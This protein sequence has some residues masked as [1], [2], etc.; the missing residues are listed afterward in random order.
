MLCFIFPAQKAVRYSF[1]GGGKLDQ[2]QPFKKTV[3]VTKGH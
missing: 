1:E 3:I 2:F